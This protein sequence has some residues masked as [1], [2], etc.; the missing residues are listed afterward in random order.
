MLLF[1]GKRLEIFL[2]M[3]MSFDYNLFKS[4]CEAQDVPVFTPHQFAQKAGMVMCAITMYPNETP[5]NAYNKF[6]NEHRDVPQ[7]YT[8]A[9]KC[10]GCGGGQVK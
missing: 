5:S 3:R 4:Q 1:G 2:A 10:G 8:P 7:V 6:I 9:T